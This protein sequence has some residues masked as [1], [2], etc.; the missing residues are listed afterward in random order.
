MFKKISICLLA[1][2]ALSMG[3]CKK[4]DVAVPDLSITPTL[5]T[6]TVDVKALAANETYSKEITVATTAVTDGLKTAGGSAASVKKAVA[7]SF[8]LK[9]AD[10]ATWTFADVTSGEV[11]VDGTVIGTFVPGTTGKVATFKAPATQA[12]LKASFL[13]ST[14]FVVKLTVTAKNAT[15]ASQVTGTLKTKIDFSL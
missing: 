14:G 8:E 2:V 12:D 11:A 3:A 1:V 6:G 7:T 4:I 5:L 9:I 13:K 15:T 10:A